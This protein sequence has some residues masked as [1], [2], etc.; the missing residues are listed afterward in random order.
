MFRLH[1]D[2]RVAPLTGALTE[3]CK[4]VVATDKYPP[5]RQAIKLL[6]SILMCLLDHE[7]LRSEFFV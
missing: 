1:R 5:A 6:F 4:L 3:D 2:K 7:T